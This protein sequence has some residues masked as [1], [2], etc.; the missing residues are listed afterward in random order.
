MIMSLP[1][2]YCSSYAEIQ[3]GVLYVYRVSRFRSLMFELTYLSKKSHCIY[4][5]RKLRLSFKNPERTLDHMY[6]EAIGG[7]T[8]TDNLAVCCSSCNS[9]KRAMT[10]QEYLTFLSLP[11]RERSKYAKRVLSS[12]EHIY[13]STG[14]S[15]P[16]EW[17]E[18][19]K[20]SSIRNVS[21][22]EKRGNL[23]I[24]VAKFYSKYKNFPFPVI[25]DRKGVVL[26]NYAVY[27]YA[28]DNN[29]KKIPI[30]KLENVD[31][32]DKKNYL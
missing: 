24:K 21:I 14:F 2:K 27:L 9:E 23:Y 15:L 12:R 22:A 16:N 17:V 20:T 8:I 3:K 7:V 31:C 10:V 28:R 25:V 19:V 30:I 1:H 29:I 18:I 26:Y 6:P 13:Y 32:R 4:C 5:G 11:N